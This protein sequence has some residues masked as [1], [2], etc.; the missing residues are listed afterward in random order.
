MS[1]EPPHWKH[2]RAGAKGGRALARV[3][4]FRAAE[5]VLHADPAVISA[6]SNRRLRDVIAAARTVEP[7][8][9]LWTGVGAVRT[10]RDLP[11]LP[12]TERDHLQD[13]PVEARLTR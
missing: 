8:R 7:Y 10:V 12:I 6:L 13:T 5:R 4:Q 9:A 11:R 3:R 1:D 2:P